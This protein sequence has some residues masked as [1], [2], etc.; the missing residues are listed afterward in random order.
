[1]K[2][3]FKMRRKKTQQHFEKFGIS[4]LLFGYVGIVQKKKNKP[5]N[6]QLHT[7]CHT[8]QTATEY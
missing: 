5:N 1:M 3:L 2:Q 7:E 8:S 6:E 4:T